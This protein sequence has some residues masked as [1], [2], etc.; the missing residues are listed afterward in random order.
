MI[1][2]KKAFTLIELMVTLVIGLLLLNFVFAFQFNFVKELKHLEA[3]E[4]LAM[5][6]FKVTELVMRGFRVNNDYISG[7]ISLDSYNNE[8]KYKAHLA[9]AKQIEFKDESGYLNIEDKNSDKEY[10]Y[11]KVLTNDSVKLKEVKD[12]NGVTISSVYAVEF[13]SEIIPEYINLQTANPKYTKYTR[14]VYT[15]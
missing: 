13:N 11:K 4:K 5:E 15:K 10:A 12:T 2:T 9:P 7:V 8:T 3:K 6:S 1:Y 14:L